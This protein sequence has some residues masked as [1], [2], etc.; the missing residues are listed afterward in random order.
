M[1]G[2]CEKSN[3]E[4]EKMKQV[5][6][7]D[8]A[9]SSFLEALNVDFLEWICK[10]Q[11]VVVDGDRERDFVYAIQ[12]HEPVFEIEVGLNEVTA[13]KPWPEFR[14]LEGDLP[15]EHCKTRCFV[16]FGNEVMGYGYNTD[17]GMLVNK[18][19]GTVKTVNFGGDL[20]GR[21]GSIKLRNGE[22][23]AFPGQAAG[24]AKWKKD[25]GFSGFL[26]GDVKYQC[27]GGAEDGE[28][29]V[30]CPKWTRER[31]VVKLNPETGGTEMIPFKEYWGDE[32]GERAFWGAVGNGE[33]VWLLPWDSAHVGFLKK[34]AGQVNLV[35][36]VFLDHPEISH[37]VFDPVTK[38]I[39]AIG[40]RLRGV[41][42]IDTE[43]REIEV[44]PFSPDLVER[45]GDST[46]S[47]DIVMGP[48]GYVYPVPYG[49]PTQM[50]IDP[51][52]GEVEWRDL[53]DFCESHGLT[54]YGGYGIF[55]VA[56]RFENRVYL[57]SGRSEKAAFLEWNA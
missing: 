5:I 3:S 34:G 48:D 1:V 23:I 24:F 21:I 40:R 50:R 22:Q 42:V 11:K 57:G 28:G 30:I 16:D 25:G 56:K 32:Y 20:R 33:E 43:E 45:L 17:Q 13:V 31:E 27:R 29:F 10:T 52:T 12:K 49:H 14:F 54:H 2:R 47:F 4:I 53:T 15:G 7:S 55:T 41:L 8:R 35:G 51:E 36:S 37:G 46:P 38:K 39:F 44:I 26:G 9:K 6:R 18:W 19:N